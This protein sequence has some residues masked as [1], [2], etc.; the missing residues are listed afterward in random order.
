MVQMISVLSAFKRHI[1]RETLKSSTVNVKKNGIK[2]DRH[3][4]RS[5]RTTVMELIR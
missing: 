3:N 4:S 2:G 1:I 5:T